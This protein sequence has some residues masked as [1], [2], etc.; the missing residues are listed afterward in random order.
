MGKDKNGNRQIKTVN[1]IN[2][3]NGFNLRRNFL[4]AIDYVRKFAKKSFPLKY[5]L[6]MVK[7]KKVIQSENG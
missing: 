6:E 7:S 2:L 1:G 4:E 3:K 5:S